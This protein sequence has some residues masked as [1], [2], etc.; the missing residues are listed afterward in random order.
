MGAHEISATHIYAEWD[1]FRITEK[2][3]KINFGERFFR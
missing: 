2:V 1:K 3:R